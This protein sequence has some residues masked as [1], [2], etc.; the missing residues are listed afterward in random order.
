MAETMDGMERYEKTHQ[1][2]QWHRVNEQML[3]LHEALCRHRIFFKARFLQ[4][5]CSWSSDSEVR[6]VRQILSAAK[7]LSY[8]ILRFTES[9]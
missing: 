9:G 6:N 3:C 7:G 4:R 5:S 2:E 8:K 1:M